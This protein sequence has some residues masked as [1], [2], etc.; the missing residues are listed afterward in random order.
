LS[1]QR[2]EGVKRYLVEAMGINPAQIE[3]HGYGQSKFIV[4]PRQLAPDAPLLE[5]ESEISRQQ[6]NRRVIIV[7][8]TN[9]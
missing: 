4:Q 1:Q 8:H 2:A 6:P 5:V 3:T 7:V 9:E